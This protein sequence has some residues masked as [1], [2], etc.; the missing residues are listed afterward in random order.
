MPSAIEVLLPSYE[1]IWEASSEAA[2]REALQKRP[3]PYLVSTATERLWN[4]QKGTIKPFEASTYG[5]FVL[6]LG[7]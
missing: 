4:H 6:V 3:V 1:E 5:M 2:W 7:M